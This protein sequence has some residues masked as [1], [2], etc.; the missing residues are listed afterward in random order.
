MYN[1]TTL[2]SGADWFI[3]V[4]KAWSFFACNKFVNLG[5][6]VRGGGGFKH[7]YY[8]ACIMTSVLVF[9]PVPFCLVLGRIILVQVLWPIE[10]LLLFPVKL[11]SI[12]CRSKYLAIA[13][14]VWIWRL[15][16]LDHFNSGFLLLMQWCQIQLDV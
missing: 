7:G 3:D 1:S 12:L 8:S 4:C 13:G 11:D 6:K 9:R 15:Q 10:G 5:A 2:Q 14:V 16:R